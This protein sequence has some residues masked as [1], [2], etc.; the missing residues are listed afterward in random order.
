MA[1]NI[2]RIGPTTKGAVVTSM[3]RYLPYLAENGPAMR[4]PRRPPRVKMDETR[5]NSVEFIG[6]HCGREGAMATE[7][8]FF[9]HVMIDWGALSSA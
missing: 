5:P 3:A 2:S 6:I 8:D 4:A 7:S 1:A 9:S